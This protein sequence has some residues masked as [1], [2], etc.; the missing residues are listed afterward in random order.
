MKPQL[1]SV[2]DLLWIAPLSIVLSEGMSSL[3][4]GDWVTGWLGFSFL[5]LLSLSLLT[6]AVRWAGGGGF[7]TPLGKHSGLPNHQKALAWMVAVA[8]ILRLAVSVTLY[9]ALPVDGY[10]EPDDN[11][12]F[13][14]TDA[15]RRDNQAWTWRVPSGRS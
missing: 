7:D 8:F 5:F 14:F 11:A 3:Q 15:H 6:L 9:V 1:I 10:D 13:V 12:G 4:P 2:R